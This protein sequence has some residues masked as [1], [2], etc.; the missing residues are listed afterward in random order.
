MSEFL[1][2]NS[3]MAALYFTRKSNIQLNLLQTYFHFIHPLLSTRHLLARFCC[4]F[5]YSVP[6]QA[7]RPVVANSANCQLKP[8]TLY[9][10]FVYFLVGTLPFFRYFRRSEDNWNTAYEVHSEVVPETTSK[11]K[12]YEVPTQRPSCPSTR[13][14]L[15]ICSFQTSRQIYLQIF[16]L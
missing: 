2:G 15:A 4:I 14:I 8:L 13:H 1:L 7:K 5:Q 6:K 12:A 10:K 11:E 9:Y 16:V 3:K